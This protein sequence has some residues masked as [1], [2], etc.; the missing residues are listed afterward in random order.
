MDELKQRFDQGIRS[1]PFAPPEQVRRRRRRRVPA[2]LTAAAIVLVALAAVAVGVSE[3]RRDQAGVP[4]AGATTKASPTLAGFSCKPRKD[5]GGVETGPPEPMPATLALTAADLGTTWAANQDGLPVASASASTQELGGSVPLLDERF[6]PAGWVQAA[7]LTAPKPGSLQ[8][9]AEYLAKT[10]RYSFFTGSGESHDQLRSFVTQ[11]PAST[12]ARVIDE[13]RV[14][15]SCDVRGWKNYKIVSDSPSSGHDLVV[16]TNPHIS[17]LPLMMAVG[18]VGDYITVVQYLPGSSP[19][20]ARRIRELGTLAIK[21]LVAQLPDPTGPPDSRNAQKF[22][23]PTVSAAAAPGLLTAQDVGSGWRVDTGE[24][25]TGN[26]E[27]YDWCQRPMD[28]GAATGLASAF[29]RRTDGSKLEVV[30]ESAYAYPNEAAAVAVMA[31]LGESTTECNIKAVP[32]NFGGDESLLVID[33]G[34]ASHATVRVGAR[35]AFV[36]LLGG[37]GLNAF[38]GGREAVDKIVTRAGERL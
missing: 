28:N 31:K 24:A 9:P 19:V 36:D 11:Y 16:L 37:Q 7:A 1:L 2:E 18:R 6:L 35:I 32:A 5:Y 34:G 3:V 27:L 17:K 10:S 13:L 38:P 21:R 8:M 12:A 26:G 14:A 15:P 22:P 25:G 4:A 29:F 23:P 33:A 20:D 30:G